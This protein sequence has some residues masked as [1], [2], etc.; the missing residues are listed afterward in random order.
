MSGEDKITAAHRARRAVIYLRQSSA[1]RV[2][3]NLESQRLQYALADRARALGFAH[4]DILDADLGISAAVAAQRRADFERLLGSVALGEIGLILSRELSRLLRT[5]KDF[6]QLVELCQLFGTLLGD[7]ETLYDTSRMDDQLVLGIKATISV[8]ELKVLKLRLLQGKEHKARRGALYPRLPPGY[9]WAAP[10]TVAK[11][12][13]V[14]VQEAIALLFAKF[15]ETWSIR[16]T[17]KWF[18][19][20]DVPLPVTKVIGTKQAVVFQMPRPSFIASV[21]HNP[22]YAGAYAWGRHA[23]EPVWSAGVLRKRRTAVAAPEQARIF[24]RD[25][26][27]GYIDWAT[28]EE[29]QRMMRRNSWRGGTDETAGA[30]RAGQG[31][32]A[33][34]LRCGRCGR[35][36][37]VRYWGKAGTAARYLC[38]G[39]FGTAAGR[40]CVGFGGALVDRRFGE[41]IVRVL[42]PLGMQASL[43]ALE[44]LGA[45][46]D[47]RRQVYA[48]QLEQLEYETAR[49]AEQYHAVDARNRLVAAELERRW[50]AKL[51]ETER[52]RTVLTELTA[53]HQPPSAEERGALLAFGERVADLWHHP[54]C[55]I[56]LKKQIARTVLEDVLVDEDPPGTL[57]FIVHW[58]GGSHTAFTMTKVGSKTVHRT[59]DADLEVIRKMASRYG[60]TDIARVLNKLGRR[61]GKGKPWSAL[62]VKT[63]RRNHTIEG[64]RE[65]IVDPELLTLQ[66]AA[67]YTATSDTTIKKLVD[68][69]VVPMRQVVPFAPWE[70]HRADLETEP[71][72]AIFEHLKRT[73]RLSIGDPSTTQPELFEGNH[74]GDNAR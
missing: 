5:D 31:L 35:R 66:A 33:G 8:V 30:V 20:H 68:A 23:T 71:V 22:F 42:S 69:G 70:I 1:G 51:E 15:R 52:V 26:H 40:Y 43:H 39:D 74:G 53:Q 48:R 25:H 57:A 55:P 27:E 13:N 7:E 41:E 24:I 49:A 6:C 64:R 56:E 60:D 58:K 44:Q 18:R 54:A 4:V 45:Q 37:H 50:N 46:D 2:R 9:V 63:A 32:L 12:P 62:A 21:L 65:T 34:L 73:G 67:R 59:A 72:R 19:D 36:I 14:R 10:E 47:E 3:H 61:T 38:S 17:F 16:Q 11:D 28:F 29:H